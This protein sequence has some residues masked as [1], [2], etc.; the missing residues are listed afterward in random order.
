[1]KNIDEDFNPEKLN[2]N[3]DD[4]D[5]STKSEL[6]ILESKYVLINRKIKSLNNTISYL[7]S[8]TPNM[9]NLNPDKYN[10]CVLP[11]YIEDMRNFSHYSNSILDYI[12]KKINEG[13]NITYLYETFNFKTDFDEGYQKLTH[14]TLFDLGDYYDGYN[15]FE[16]YNLIYSVNDIFNGKCIDHHS[17][18]NDQSGDD[19]YEEYECSCL[20][21]W[22]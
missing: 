13:W 17:E 3:L 4:Y 16:K 10:I 21:I 19:I 5:A 11:S 12:I 1:M 22:K 7:N 2:Q 20:L 14:S 6:E 18:Y 8:K 15:I 9:F